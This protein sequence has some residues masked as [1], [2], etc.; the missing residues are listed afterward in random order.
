MKLFGLLIAVMLSFSVLMPTISALEVDTD[1]DGIKDMSVEPDPKSTDVDGD[2]IPNIDD[3]DIDGDDIPNGD[4]PDMDGDGISNDK[5]RSPY[6]PTP[7]V[8]IDWGWNPPNY[9]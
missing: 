2:N 8:P 6:G 1:G 4:D 9:D 5:D 7:R 3:P